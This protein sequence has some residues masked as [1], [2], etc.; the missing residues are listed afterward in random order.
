MAVTFIDDSPPTGATFLDDGQGA[1]S[2]NVGELRQDDEQNDIFN[3]SR[4]QASQALDMFQNHGPMALDMAMRRWQA[5]KQAQTGNTPLSETRY[6]LNGDPFEAQTTKD[7]QTLQQGLSSDV[8]R[9]TNQAPD[10]I[11]NLPE[12]DYIPNA[13]GVQDQGYNALVS[14]GRGLERFGKSM[15]T[16]FNAGLALAT[17]G[18]GGIAAKGVGAYFAGT[19][20]NQG[21]AKLGEASAIEDPNER[22]AG[23]VEGAAA[24]GLAGLGARELGKG[25]IDSMK[26]AK[27]REITDNPISSVSV[28]SSEA[29]ATEM[30][31]PQP[32]TKLPE[33]VPSPRAA[34]N[35][36]VT[37]NI[38][39]KALDAAHAS[40]PQYIP[41]GAEDKP[42]SRAAVEKEFESGQPVAQ[43]EVS[44]GTNGKP[45]F[46]DGRHR[47]AVARDQGAETIP[48]SMDAESAENA[49]KAGLLSSSQH[50]IEAEF[51]NDTIDATEKLR[52]DFD[53]SRRTAHVFNFPSDRPQILYRGI[54]QQELDYLK[55]NPEAPI[56][57]G[58][59]SAPVER[60][61]GAQYALTPQEAARAA[62]HDER[63]KGVLGQEKYVIAVDAA[64]KQFSHMDPRP[65]TTPQ[66]AGK[67]R[68]LIPKDRI[69]GN[70]GVSTKIPFKD[71]I[72][73]TSIGSDYKLSSEN[74]RKA[75]IV[76]D[77]RPPKGRAAMTTEAK[78]PTG[79]KNAYVD[80]MMQAHGLDPATDAVPESFNQWAREAGDDLKENPERQ[81]ELVDEIRDSPRALTGPETVLLTDVV[82]QREDAYEAAVKAHDSNPSEATQKAQDAAIAGLHDIAKITEEVGTS[83]GR[84]LVARRYMMARDFSLPRVTADILKAKGLRDIGD[85]SADQQA[86]VIQEAK[87]QSEKLKATA[88]AQIKADE[89]RPEREGQAHATEELKTIAAE[90]KPQVKKPHAPGKV[91]EF[92]NAKAAE[93][94]ARIKARRS[95]LSADPLG[96][97]VIASLADE[98]IIGA[99]KLANGIVK[100]KDWSESMIKDLGDYIKPTINQLFEQSKA[101]L[102]N[103]KLDPAV[104]RSDVLAKMKAR[105]ADGANVGDLH[106]YARRIAEAHVRAGIDKLE[107]LTDAVH[108]DLQAIKPD[109]TRSESRDLWSGYGK[110]TKLS[111][112]AAKVQLRDLAGQAQQTGK[113]EDMS[114]GIAPRKTGPERREKSAAE[115]RL[116]QQVNEAKKRG[117]FK[118][119][120]PENQLRTALQATERGLENRLKDLTDEF[121]LGPRGPKEP[122]PTSER[123]EQ[124]RGMIA[125]VKQS[126]AEVKRDGGYD[127]HVGLAKKYAAALKALDESEKMLNEQIQG[128]KF[129]PKPKAATFVT[130]EFKARKAQ[131][132]ALRQQR[133][134]L[135][136]LDDEISG[137]RSDRRAKELQSSIAKLDERLKSGDYSTSPIKPEID[138]RIEALKNERAAMQRELER[139]RRAASV[140]SASEIERRKLSDIQKSI[141][142]LDRRI[143]T[144]DTSIKQ[145]SASSD[146]I[147]AE[148]LKQERA[149]MQRQLDAM[150]REANRK[151]PDQAAI[152]AKKIAAV[153]KQIEALDAKLKAGDTSTKPKSTKTVS[154]TREDLMA[155]R[156]AIS[157]ELA[158]QRRP[159]YGKSKE[160]LALERWKTNIANRTAEL[161]RRT[162]AGDFSKPTRAQLRPDAEALLAQTAH[163]QA[164]V[165]YDRAL[166]AHRLGQ[167]TR[168]AKLLDGLVALRRAGVLSSPATLGKLA[169][170]A[171]HIIAT[172]PLEEG[173]GGVI[174][175]FP[176]FRR[177][178]D[179]APVQGRFSLAAEKAALAGFGKWKSDIKSYIQHGQMD[180]DALHGKEKIAPRTKLD[181]LGE[182]HGAIKSP[183]RRNA[184]ERA[185]VKLREYYGNRGE[186]VDSP[187]VREKIGVAAYAEAQRAVFTEDNIVSNWLKA[188]NLQNEKGG[189]GLGRVLRVLFPVVRIPT[190]IV[191]RIGDY[192][193]GLPTGLGRVIKAHAQGIENLSPETA[194][195]IMNNLKRGSLGAA[196]FSLGAALQSQ[197]GGF[198]APGQW[199]RKPGE[200]SEGS[201]K[202]GGLEIPPTLLHSPQMQEL[203]A[204]ATFSRKGGTINTIA[205]VFKELPFMGQTVQ[206]AISAVHD[207]GGFGKFAINQARSMLVP[208]GLHWLAQQTDLR[209]LH[210]NQAPSAIE[211]A[212]LQTRPRVKNPKTLQDYIREEIPGLRS[213]VKNKPGQ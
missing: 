21:A 30:P 180:I 195:Q 58:R 24:L 111:K 203:Q 199:K 54:S 66:L 76:Y 102:S 101:H 50:H 188:K 89:S 48:V 157:K 45:V 62:F 123:A 210:S 1:P 33:F 18:L 36:D 106:R 121:D 155:E 130:D 207:K 70:L 77:G 131:V 87:V 31:S 3:A 85:L 12:P 27:D 164:R 174:G 110:T 117:G 95:T 98:T 206:G 140:P 37:V 99:S 169:A 182:L 73:I 205:G 192:T 196:I 52:D 96:V 152:E 134:E 170:S 185:T 193:L 178:A 202:A 149:A 63:Q 212:L 26:R 139:Q 128:D 55:S 190:N 90:Q 35:E 126:L 166:E 53:S 125:R 118:V 194:D 162:A 197:I 143:Q 6:D 167:R 135:K 51:N 179:A 158:A 74:A 94:L 71:V 138:P 129:G 124:L 67:G 4:A 22:R 160:Q 59:Y 82:R 161:L 145:R 23:Y 34:A 56:M 15:V 144:G 141:D 91:Q 10:F 186:D 115:R 40:D 168:T 191:A 20:A 198:N 181:A 8:D 112:E 80:A 148:S 200:V 172:K 2:S 147:A 46:T 100:F 41:P 116:E 13:Q 97:R 142:D 16:P 39:V 137:R 213:S 132:E 88:E 84:S 19:M 204:G 25:S 175:K 122:I 42:G 5:A 146:S 78:G 150:R 92:L 159:S 105:I 151:P 68:Y 120:D 119:T 43:P 108:G 44:V 9:Y 114:K 184:F 11:Q 176:G 173:I 104:I 189:A 127:S 136:V 75:G 65:T 81:Q 28:N 7:D 32:E 208:G 47:F 153:Q 154:Q 163:K 209:K 38:D 72:K 113:L 17:G 133:N 14:G 93:A 79:V 86:T 103:A 201:I 177:L 61:H 107:P 156:A 83:S 183:A 165:A 187:A 60:V 57:G 211:R 64:G 49:R 171:A 29:A 109:I 69:S